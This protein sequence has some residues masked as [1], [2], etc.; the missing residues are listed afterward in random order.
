MNFLLDRIFGLLRDIL[1]GVVTVVTVNTLNTSELS[2]ELA[3][4]LKFCILM[5]LASK[6]FSFQSW[7]R[8]FCDLMV[9]WLELMIGI[10]EFKVKNIWSIAFWTLN[11]YCF[12][13]LSLLLCDK[14]ATFS[15]D[16]VAAQ[17]CKQWVFG[18]ELILAIIKEAFTWY[19]QI[20]FKFIII[21]K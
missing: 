19:L 9:F 18:P 4:S 17:N 15:A 3:V 2:I 16:R 13:F 12:V 1:L 6:K 21:I 10:E 8:F 14:H 5:F 11:T 20:H 7:F